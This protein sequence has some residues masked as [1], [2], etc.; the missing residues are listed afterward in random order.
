MEP[1]L[2]YSLHRSENEIY[3][4]YILNKILNLEQF[5]L[6]IFFLF[7]YNKIGGAIMKYSIE[8]GKIVEGALKHDQAKVINYTKQLVSKLEKDDDLRSAIKFQRLLS[9]QTEF[10]LTPMNSSSP[11]AIPVDTES[12]MDLADII[13]P[14]QNEIEVVLSKQNEE[15]LDSFILSYQNADK[16]NSLGINVSNSLLLYGPPGCGKTKCA[17]L[18]AKRLNLPLVVAR[19]DSLISSYLGTTAKNIRSLFDFAQKMPCVLFLDEFDAIAKARDDNNELGELKRVVNSLL[20][21]IDTMSKDSLILAATNHQ[22]LLDP[23]IWRRFEYKLEIELPDR[24][25]IAALVT[26][27]ANGL[28]S[29][30]KK[31]IVEI[32]TLLD[33]QS[34]ADIEEIVTKAIRNSVIHNCPFS[35]ANIYNE[36]FITKNIVPQN[37]NDPRELLQIKAK[38]L[39]E[40]DSKVFSLQVIA[41]ILGSSKTTIQKI[42]KEVQS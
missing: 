3:R 25:A 32:S 30:S 38:Y 23:A 40:K 2:V 22:Q 14:Y 21:N 31:E 35:I 27:F 16:L 5:V 19:L 24:E 17:Y 26:L 39:R 42:V 9:T 13:Y 12:R 28:Y 10:S 15:K 33:G 29:F 41:D 18:I 11:V 6:Y 37:C 1:V 36:L 7:R 4:T 20:Q 34:G 8:I